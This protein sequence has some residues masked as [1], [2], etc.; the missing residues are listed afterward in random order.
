[1][2]KAAPAKTE[3]LPARPAIPPELAHL[4]M[5]AEPIVQRLFVQPIVAAI[6]GKGRAPELAKF[7]SLE[8]AAEL[9]GLTPRLVKKLCRERKLAAIR[10]R[11]RW[12][13]LRSAI[14]EWKP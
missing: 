14:E 5:M 6:E 4:L 11:Q 12:K 1:M 2:S 10:D 9:L 8:E 3:V 13:V 7:V